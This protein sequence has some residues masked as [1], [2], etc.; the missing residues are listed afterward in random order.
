[1]HALDIVSQASYLARDFQLN[2]SLAKVKELIR[3][4]EIFY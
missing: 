2:K 4:F 1:M 3:R